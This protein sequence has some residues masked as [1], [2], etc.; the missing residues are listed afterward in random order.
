MTERM[1]NIMVIMESDRCKDQ[2]RLERSRH[3]DHKRLIE[4]LLQ[5][6]IEALAVL[7]QLHKPQTL[8]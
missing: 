8:I 2:E 4:R 7:L 1:M 5:M 3:E 6:F